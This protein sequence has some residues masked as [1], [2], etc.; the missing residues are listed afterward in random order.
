M[1]VLGWK[2]EDRKRG[3]SRW[4]FFL[5]P[6]SNTITDSLLY[7]DQTETTW[8]KV[9]NSE[10][11]L[12]GK[13]FHQLTSAFSVWDFTEFSKVELSEYQGKQ[14]KLRALG[15]GW[16]ADL[17]RTNT[18]SL[19]RRKAKWSTSLPQSDC[20]NLCCIQRRHLKGVNKLLLRATWFP[21]SQ[22]ENFAWCFQQVFLPSPKS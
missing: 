4:F 22:T 5:L 20:R 8:I 13:E 16:R 14:V 6:T 21:L 9:L 11:A 18:N 7:F 3:Y 15:A 2:K 10:V 1:H 19:F 12:N 17:L